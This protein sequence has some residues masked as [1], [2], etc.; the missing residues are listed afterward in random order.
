MKKNYKKIVISIVT[1]KHWLLFFVIF[2]LEFFLRFY[3]IAERNP[4]GWDQVDNAWAAKEIIVNHWYPLIGMVAKQNS[5]FYIGPLY[6]YVIAIVYFFTNLDPI[7]SGIFAG[8]SSILAFLGLFWVA[9]KLFSFEVALIAG[10]IYTVSSRQIIFDRVQWPVNFIPIVSLLVFY[11]LYKVITG[12][13]K[14]ILTVS[15]LIGLAFQMHFTAIFFPIIVFLTLP[16]FPWAWSTVG[17]LFGG[18]LILIASLIPNII[19]ELQT[20]HSESSS[21]KTFGGSYYHGFHIRR[22]IQI[23]GD[24]FIQFQ[25]YFTFDLFTIAKYF[26]VPIFFVVYLWKQL[27]NPKIKLCYLVLLWF[28]VPWFVFATYS[29]EITDYYFASNRFIALLIIAY[30]LYR[31]FAINIFFKIII[32]GVLLL[33]GFFNIQY[34]R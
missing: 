32:I 9:K 24:A 23:I 22:V 29:G 6:Y 15:V 33:Y 11:F 2:V 13:K 10:F 21:M 16:F 26:L 27:A 1:S 4:F 19:Y 31:I 14:H 28:I 20:K 34:K 17:Y 7:A 8:I 18:I 3:Q 5:G 25:A 30:L 12:E